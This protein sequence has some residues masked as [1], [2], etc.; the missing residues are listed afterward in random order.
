MIHIKWTKNTKCVHYMLSNHDSL[1]RWFFKLLFTIYIYI[2][3]GQSK[4]LQQS[5][6]RSCVND[7]YVYILLNKSIYVYCIWHV[8]RENVANWK[9]IYIQYNCMYIKTGFPHLKWLLAF[10]HAHL[11]YLLLLFNI[12]ILS[13]KTTQQR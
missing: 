4:R 1:N 3:C 13:R 7:V 6:L 10:M 5:S 12:W 9:Y 11:R 2:Y 8:V